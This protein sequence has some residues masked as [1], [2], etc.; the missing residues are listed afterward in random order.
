[1]ATDENHRH[2]QTRVILAELANKGMSLREQAEYLRPQNCDFC[3]K[4]GARQEQERIIKLL[5]P[6]RQRFQGK[7]PEEEIVAD[8]I[9]EVIELIKESNK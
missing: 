5:T 1:M 2:G 6:I 3:L 7:G 8:T 9:F 4:I